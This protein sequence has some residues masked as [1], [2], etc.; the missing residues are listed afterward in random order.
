[1]AELPASPAEDRIAILEAETTRLEAELLRLRES[2]RRYRFSAALAARLVWVADAGGQMQFLD[3]PFVVLTGMSAQAGLGS[4]WLEVV[5]PDD[6]ERTRDFWQ[7]CVESGELYAAEFRVLRV[8]GEYRRTRSRAIAARGE[9]GAIRCWYGTTE[10]IEEETRSEDARRAAED[11]LRE[12]ERLYRNTLEMSQQIAWTAEADGSGLVL[13]DRFRELTGLA[14]EPGDPS[15]SVHPDDRDEVL[16]GWAAAVASGKRYDARFRMRLK[17]GSYRFAHVRAAPQLDDQGQVLRWYGVT[18]DVHEQQQAQLAQHEAEERYR[19]AAQATNDAIWD[20]DLVEDLTDWGENA[21]LVL[22]VRGGPL[23]RTRGSWW[24]D[25]LH[26][27]ERADIVESFGEA[28]RS[29]AARWTRTYRFRRDDGGYADIFDRG[30]IIRDAH[31]RGVRAVGAMQD[32]TERNRAEAEIRRMQAELIHVSR[33]SAMGTMA[34]TLAH[35]LNQPLAAISNFLSGTKRIAERPDVSREILLEALD[36]AE[37]ASRRAGEILRRLR[38]LVSRGK[39]SV[40]TEHLPE[41]IEEARALAFDEA[42]AGISYHLKLDP[43]AAWVKVD[44]IQIQQVMINLVRNAVEAM[45]G[46]KQREVTIG[47]RLA[48]QMIEIEVAD[49]GPGIPTQN[50]ESLFSEFMTTKSEGMGLGLPI[51][52]TII[53]AHG[54]AIRA[55][56]RAE[57]GASFVFTLQRA[58]NQR[59]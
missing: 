22:G 50:I 48:G 32:L 17:D 11:A 40:Q 21:A 30:F 58:K 8:D 12:S 46:C 10:D 6:R 9:D 16:A 29:G 2:E 31:G 51:S 42:A 44:R 49:T 27:D 54:G 36:G 28:I 24:S 14:G 57:G 47:T 19:L 1:M 20:C 55:E 13:S 45:A 7:G 15:D 4:G 3:N 53:E 33:L 34:S 41:L 56:N 25:R 37:A 5:H 26:P 39:V 38:D 23:G 59:L 43:K 52:R 18:E 35:E